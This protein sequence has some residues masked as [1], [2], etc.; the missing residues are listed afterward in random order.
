MPLPPLKHRETQTAR[1]SRLNEACRV[2]PLWCEHEGVALTLARRVICLRPEL[3]QLGYSI[4]GTNARLYAPAEW[5]QIA[6]A[7]AEYRRRMGK[8]LKT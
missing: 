1:E 5:S 3:R 2:L 4:P 8:R 7:V 6:R